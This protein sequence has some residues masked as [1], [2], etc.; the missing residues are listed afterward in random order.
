[1]D[2]PE[3][4]P[5]C[6]MPWV[7]P[8]CHLRQER[9]KNNGNTENREH[10]HSNPEIYTL[11][12]TQIKT[13]LNINKVKDVARRFWQL[14]FSW[15]KILSFQFRNHQQHCGICHSNLFSYSLSLLSVAF[16]QHLALRDISDQRNVKVRVIVHSTFSS[17][18]KHCLVFLDTRI[19]L[20]LTSHFKFW[21][22]LDT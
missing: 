10:S 19:P 17:R 15:Q 7:W 18:C 12:A 9:E 14:V 16:V 1:M 6:P 2:F 5:W 11:L 22:M 4:Y 13:D 21:L 3:S 20:T 8:P